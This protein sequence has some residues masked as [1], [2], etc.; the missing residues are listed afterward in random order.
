MVILMTNIEK[1]TKIFYSFALI[2]I[3]AGFILA[4]FY[5]AYSQIA[6][7][8]INIGT[9]M[10]FVT[11]IKARRYRKGPVKD[12]RTI[13]IGAYG[14]SY[15]WFVSLILLTIIFWI[16][17]FELVQLTVTQV[18]ATMLFVMVITAKGFQWYLFRKGDV[19]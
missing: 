10:I 19:E 16:D 1:Y 17:Y 3:I 11:F 12:E 5:E 6:I 7:S 13:K 18:L 15:S 4:I 9:I 14:L 8:L 2:F